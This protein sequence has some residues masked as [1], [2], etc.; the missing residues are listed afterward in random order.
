MLETLV[1]TPSIDKIEITILKPDPSNA[2][3]KL[4]IVA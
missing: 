4:A 3:P 2:N 1:S